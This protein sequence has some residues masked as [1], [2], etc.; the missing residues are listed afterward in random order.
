MLK[1]IL[2]AAFLVS[3]ALPARAQMDQATEDFVAANLIAIFYHEL[4]HALI[5]QLDIPIYGQEEDAADV[6]SV[7]MVD[8]LFEEADAQRIATAAAFGYLGAARIRAASGGDVAWWD[9]HA[10]DLQRYYNIVCLFFGGNPAQRTQFAKTLELPEARARSCPE[11]FQK[12]RHAWGPIIERLEANGPAP[13]LWYSDEARS[14]RFS[15]L[16]D[17]VI[18]FEVREFNRRMSL[19]RDVPLPVRIGP[20]G[21]INAFYDPNV[22]EIIM[23]TEFAEYLAQFAK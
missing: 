21:F 3:A 8:R 22:P 20:C 12:A 17:E 7:V 2:A 13:S 4:A 6:M 10:P 11:E 19:E 18:G 14:D 16:T 5:D 9:V 23:C 15:R 1:H